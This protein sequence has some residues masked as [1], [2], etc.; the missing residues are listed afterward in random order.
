MNKNPASTSQATS[1]TMSDLDIISGCLNQT[2]NELI[3]ATEN[4]TLNKSNYNNKFNLLHVDKN[5]IAA[6]SSGGKNRFTVL[7]FPV[8]NDSCASIIYNGSE[9]YICKFKENLKYIM[10]NYGKNNIAFH[11]IYR[12]SNDNEKNNSVIQK[13][14]TIKDYFAFEELG[15]NDFILK[16]SKELDG[17]NFETLLSSP[18]SP[19]DKNNSNRLS[20]SS[21]IA[22]IPNTIPSPDN[23]RR[24]S[25]DYASS[26]PVVI[27]RKRVDSP[28]DDKNNWNR[29]NPSSSISSIHSTVFSPENQRRASQDLSSSS[30]VVSKKKKVASPIELDHQA[31][32]DSVDPNQDPVGFFKNAALKIQQNKDISRY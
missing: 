27:K 5:H 1:D 14:N 10:D 3:S 18:K 4:S 17:I 16:V 32:Q 12:G 25:Q 15:L 31:N 21:S 11:P 13:L 2:L 9:I 30:P 8:P 19:N 23:Q 24:A 22:S 20:P 28:I 7:F 26:S 6:M 29:L